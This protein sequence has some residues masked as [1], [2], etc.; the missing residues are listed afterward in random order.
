MNLSFEKWKLKKPIPVAAAIDNHDYTVVQWIS[1]TNLLRLGNDAIIVVLVDVTNH[2]GGFIT[3][4]VYE[5]VLIEDAY[6]GSCCWE[7]C[8]RKGDDCGSWDCKTTVVPKDLKSACVN[9]YSRLISNI[10]K[11]RVH[12]LVDIY[13]THKYTKTINIKNMYLNVYL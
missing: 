13:D 8:G 6:F 5:N 10:L 9:F 7:R 11:Y 2:L 4:V 12:T 3:K 1:D